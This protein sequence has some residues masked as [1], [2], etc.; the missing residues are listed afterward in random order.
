MKLKP[1]LIGASVLAAMAAGTLAAAQDPQPLYVQIAEIEIDPTQ[2]DAYKAAVSEHAETAV[3][4][5]PGVQ[6]L[7]V[8]SDKDNPSHIT[9]LEIYASAEA[10][11]THL[12]APHFKKY[13]K[14]TEK[15]VRSLKLVKA[16]P[17]ALAVKPN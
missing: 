5:E 6:T 7:Y 11:K 17:V 4:I 14:I 8:V 9:V 3:R 13:K 12:E 2:L 16:I 10:Y 15:M 1:L